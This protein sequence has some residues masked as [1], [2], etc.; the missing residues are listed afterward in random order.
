MDL[1]Q[2]HIRSLLGSLVH[3]VVD[4]PVGCL[5]NGTVYPINYGYI[6]G[7][8]GGDGEEQD[9]YI[10]GVSGPVSSFDG[11]VVGAV[12]RKNDCED[13]L[14][15]AP[16][17]SI[18]HQGQIAAAVHFQ[19]QY[20]DSHILSLFRKSCG[21]IPWRKHG[22]EREYLIVFEAFSQCWSFPKGHME[23]GE[24]ETQT[25][26]RELYEE[27]GL[28]AQLDAGKTAVIE[29]SVSPVVRKQ[30][31]FFLGQAHG[32][33]SPRPGEISRLKW[34]TASQLKNF[35]FPDTVA[36]ITKLIN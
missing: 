23:M 8:P 3:V 17:G 32:T 15:V 28:T 31:V 18:F 30:V 14:V 36:A 34:I 29:Y 26:L 2:A 4:R 9:A 5:H 19:E 35:L 20:F 22:I 12:C 21:V 27:T 16:K 10:L 1:R 25:A 24:T 13:K 7:L 33:P 6:P 11:Q